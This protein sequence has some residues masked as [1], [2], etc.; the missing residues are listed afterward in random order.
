MGK[1]IS[2][3]RVR[4]FFE[5]ALRSC[6]KLTVTLRYSSSGKGLDSFA[7]QSNQS[8]E[9][10]LC[11]DS[12]GGRIGRIRVRTTAVKC[13]SALVTERSSRTSHR[14]PNIAAHCHLVHTFMPK[15]DSDF[16][17]VSYTSFTI[18]RPL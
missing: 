16:L 2:R 3:G 6:C 1:Q 7:S 18:F 11:G 12:E 13:S 15:T 4:R 5:A 14:H 17:H 8:W 9:T 10:L